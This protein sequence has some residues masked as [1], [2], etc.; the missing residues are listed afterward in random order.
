MDERSLVFLLFF[1]G[2]QIVQLDSQRSVGGTCEDVGTGSSLAAIEHVKDVLKDRP[3]FSLLEGDIFLQTLQ[4]GLSDIDD[5]GFLLFEANEAELD[6]VHTCQD[7][8]TDPL[9]DT[10]AVGQVLLEHEG[11]LGLLDVL[12]PSAVSCCLHEG[13]DEAGCDGRSFSIGPD[14]GAINADSSVDIN[15]IESYLQVFLEIAKLLLGLF[16][17]LF[18]TI[19]ALLS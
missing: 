16:L 11:T 8:L 5:L 19:F 6:C 12:D 9:L 18:L 14:L 15:V 2:R 17:F 10:A 7:S 13:T 3:A 1:L 4:S